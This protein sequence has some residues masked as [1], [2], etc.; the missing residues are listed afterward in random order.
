MAQ[1]NSAQHPF[2]SEDKCKLWWDYNR[3]NIRCPSVYGT[4]GIPHINDCLPCH[5][6]RPLVH[7][8]T[9]SL[10]SLNLHADYAIC[11][12]SQPRLAELPNGPLPCQVHT[13]SS[14]RKAEAVDYN[15]HKTKSLYYIHVKG[16]FKKWCLREGSPCPA[17]GCLQGWSANDVTHGNP[18]ALPSLPAAHPSCPWGPHVANMAEPVHCRC[19][20]TTP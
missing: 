7:G 16:C 10:P 5:N 17:V 8:Q 9:P 6:P 4:T 11:F 12:H 18:G 13:F 15:S 1:G 14:Q 20:S 3:Q 19:A 2:P